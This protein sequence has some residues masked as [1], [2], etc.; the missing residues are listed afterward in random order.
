MVVIAQIVV[1][2]HHIVMLADTDVSEDCSASIFGPEEAGSMFTQN[3]YIYLQDCTVSQFRTAQS[4][5]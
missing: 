1:L 4:K 2:W 5:N 3:I